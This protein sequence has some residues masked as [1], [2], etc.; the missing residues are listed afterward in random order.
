MDRGICLLNQSSRPWALPMAVAHSSWKV[1][2][3][4]SNTP[5]V[6]VVLVSLTFAEETLSF[7]VFVGRKKRDKSGV[8]FYP[9]IFLQPPSFNIK[10][11]RHKAF[12][13]GVI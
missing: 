10:N 13:F 8:N 3:S 5:V 9:D 12:Q 1:V 2:A 6:A 4:P 7:S 11:W